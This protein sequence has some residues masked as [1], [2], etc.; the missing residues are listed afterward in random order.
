MND[1][2]P[3]PGPKA[4]AAGDS[5]PSLQANQAAQLSVDAVLHAQELQRLN[6]QLRE[7]ASLLNKAQDAILVRDMEHRITYWNK[8]AERLYGWTAEEAMGR[9][10]ETLLKTDPKAFEQ[11]FQEVSRTGE[12]TGELNKIAKDGSTLI[13]EAHWTLVRDGMGQPVSVLDI[14]TDIS[15]RKK[16]ELQMF[17]AQRMES[18]GTLAGGV[19][20][21]LNNVL[22]PILMSLELL[23]MHCPD[24]ESED[25]L[26]TLLLSAQRG[27]DLVKQLLSFSRGIE[28]ERVVVNVAHIL[29][30]LNRVIREVFPKNIEIRPLLDGEGWTVVGDAT[31]LHQ[32]FLNLFVNARDAM[33]GGGRLSVTMENVV[34]DEMYAGTN[35][36]AKPGAYLRVTV[37][38]TGIGMPPKILDRI[39]EPFFTTKQLGTGTGLGLSTTSAIVKSHGGFINVYSEPGKGTTF[40]VHLPASTAS[41]AKESGKIGRPALPKGNDELIL[42][43]DD[44]ASIR[45]VAQLTLERFGY[46][47][48]LASQGAE[49]LAIYA[50]HQNQIA[51]VLTDMAMPVMDGPSMIL[52]LKA[53]DPRIRIIGSSGL[54]THD[55]PGTT[56]SMVVDHFLPKPYTA[57]T[58]LIA[59]AA[60]LKSS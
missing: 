29:R 35:A 59:I 53:L 41:V 57:E 19:A 14:N 44:E 33:P 12:W 6:E 47:V 54:T 43:V 28:G 51:V 58:M 1:S 56:A 25:L 40:H 13:V 27:A 45:T 46:R 30:D 48:L 36:E 32:V 16:A 21:D 42:I 34:L 26:H 9:S 15:A 4:E 24:P 49:A 31:Q 7:K 17:R 10:A 39:F 18:I 11:A 52:A 8:S 22:A 5:D 50:V 55:T 23:R 20:H 3:S 37:A 2:N 38:D 60:V